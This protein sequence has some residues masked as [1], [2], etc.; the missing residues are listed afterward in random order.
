M[1]E[2]FGKRFDVCDRRCVRVQRGC[3][4]ASGRQ[5]LAKSDDLQPSDDPVAVCGTTIPCD[6]NFAGRTLSPRVRAIEAK[7]ENLTC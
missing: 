2:R 6:D 4:P 1:A 5:D 3:L 7:T